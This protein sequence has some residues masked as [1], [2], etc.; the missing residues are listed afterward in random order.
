MYQHL[1]LSPSAG[2]VLCSPPDTIRLGQPY[3]TNQTDRD[4]HEGG[5]ASWRR[6]YARKERGRGFW[7][8][9]QKESLH[10]QFGTS[11]SSMIACTKTCTLGSVANLLEKPKLLPAG[12]GDMPWVAFLSLS[13]SLEILTPSAQRKPSVLSNAE[14]GLGVRKMPFLFRRIRNHSVPFEHRTS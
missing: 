10:I 5:S 7:P 9:L 12:L 14:S 11:A 4:Q 1:E 6:E 8:L 3:L 2:S 13:L